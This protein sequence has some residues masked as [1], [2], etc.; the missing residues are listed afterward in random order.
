MN[1]IQQKFLTFL[2][3]FFKFGR[4]PSV[5]TVTIILTGVAASFMKTSHILSP[6]D[7]YEN[8]NSTD[9]HGLVCV[10]FLAVL[11]VFVGGN[12]LFRKMQLVNFF[13]TF[14]CKR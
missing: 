1:K 12:K 2:I 10:Q 11:N 14:P 9:V 7:L 6:F 5:N 13:I 3:Y 8:F 4:L